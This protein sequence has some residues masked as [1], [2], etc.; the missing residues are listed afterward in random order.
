MKMKRIYLLMIGVLMSIDLSAGG[1]Q[2]N[3]QNNRSLGMG[4]T[5][6]GFRLGAASGFY[7]P[8]ALSFSGTEVIIGLNLV[9]ANIGYR[10]IE[11]G[12][13]MASNNN[14]LGT[15]FHGYAAI[16]PGENSK[17]VFGLAAYTPFGSSVSYED[18]WKLQAALREISLRSI[19]YQGTVSYQLTERLGIGVGYVFGTGEFALRRA[20]PIQD[21]DGSYGEANLSGGGIGHGFNVGIY[22][23]VADNISIGASYRSG[24][25]IALDEGIAQFDVSPALTNAFPET[26]FQSGLALPGVFNVGIAFKASEKL[27]IAAEVNYVG[28]S[29][30][31]TLSFDFDENTD[32][33]Q[34]ANSPRNYKNVAILRLGGE[35]TLNERLT[36]RAG[37]YYDFTPVQDG[38]LTPETPDMD[39]LGITLGASYT[40]N[41]F[42][43]DAAFLYI[44][45]P[46]RRDTN[47]ESGY[48]GR[49]SSNALVPGISFRYK[50]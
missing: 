46:E 31:D 39:K 6:V 42:S 25:N 14:G 24:V 16:R 32:Q 13:Y 27:M 35:Y 34:D 48:S 1:F 37:F 36:L 12:I 19:F 5:G 7:N 41:N 18:D 33:L 49:W 30:Y 20:V 43:I 17:F 10:E 2:L 44:H 40:I 15:P 47:F 11:P 23:E 21:Q 28:W 22:Y 45:G 8:G 26:N 4:H 50:F 29:S 9:A 38:Y 3:L